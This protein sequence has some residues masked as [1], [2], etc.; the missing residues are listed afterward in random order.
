MGLRDRPYKQ[1]FLEDKFLGKVKSQR[2]SKKD[3][4]YKVVL[5]KKGESQVL[6][7]SK[8]RRK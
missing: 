5:M 8:R 3:K 7:F 6:K 2:Y 1:V 4:E